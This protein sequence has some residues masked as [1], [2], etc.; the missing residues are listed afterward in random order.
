VLITLVGNKIDLKDKREVSF[1]EG[2]KFANANGFQFFEA[3]AQIGEKVE[4]VFQT[5]AKKI[6]AKIECGELNPDSEEV[7]LPNV[8]VGS[9]EGEKVQ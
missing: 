2:E 4:E 6:L 5:A 7:L 1:E 3:S 8:A 9:S